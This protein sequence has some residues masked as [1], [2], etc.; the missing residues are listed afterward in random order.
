[1]L[2]IVKRY[3]NHKNWKEKQFDITFIGLGIL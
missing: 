3:K 2:D 1:M